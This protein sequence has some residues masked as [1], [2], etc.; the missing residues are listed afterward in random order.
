MHYFAYGSNLNFIQMATRCPKATSLNKTK[1]LNYKFIINSEG[2]ATIVPSP[3]DVVEG[4][5]WK[6]TSEC[7]SSLDFHEGVTDNVYLKEKVLLDC[8]TEALTYIATDTMPGKPFEDYLARILA[9]AENFSL[10]PEYT[11]FLKS[12]SIEFRTL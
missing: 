2:D 11:R 3:G 6:L 12:F 10:S 4:G 8:G 1:L 5:L 9:G 7:I